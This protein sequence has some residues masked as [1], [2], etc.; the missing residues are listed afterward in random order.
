M[1]TAADLAALDATAQAALVHAREVTAVEL[2]E[3]AIERIEKLNPTLNAVITPMFDQARAAAAATPTGPLAGV[4]FLMKDLAADVEGVRFCEGSR[5]LRDNVAT[6][7]S[8]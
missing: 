8:E 6:F 2:V 7:S 5:F 3:A 4:P 1:T